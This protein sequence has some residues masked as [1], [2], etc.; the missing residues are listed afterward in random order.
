MHWKYKFLIAEGI[1]FVGGNALDSIEKRETFR[2]AR[3]TAD[4]LGKPLL[5]AG[6]GDETEN[7]FIEPILQSDA[8]LDV[9][10]RDVPNFVLGSVEDMHMFGDKQFGVAFCS[11]TL[12]HVDDPEKALAE[13]Q[14]VAD[15]A[16]VCAPS[17]ENIFYSHFYP[18][19]K[20]RFVDGE[21]IRTNSE[22]LFPILLAANALILIL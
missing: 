20:W 11:H 9:V 6:C 12:E 18:E 10:P 19:H 7:T 5:N 14:R 17:P 8:N 22:I 16:Y 2:A 4:R 1:I 3:E 13:L 21:P 15:Y